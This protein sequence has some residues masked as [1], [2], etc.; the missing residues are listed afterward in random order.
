MSCS[1]IGESRRSSRAAGRGEPHGYRGSPCTE[2]AATARA[3][4]AATPPQGQPTRGAP[5][6]EY[7]RRC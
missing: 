6:R 7:G 2:A 4:A 1:R 3:A 5:A